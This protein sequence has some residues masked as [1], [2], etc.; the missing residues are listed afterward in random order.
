MPLLF[1]DYT[2]LI[3]LAYDERRNDNR[4]SRLL[5]DPT[6]ANIRQEC[7][8][9]HNERI[10]KGQIEEDIL[11]AFFGVPPAGK[12]FDYVIEKHHAD[13]FRPL[14]SLIKKKVKNPSLITVELLAWLLDFTPRPLAYAQKILAT[15]SDLLVTGEN[16]KN[17]FEIDKAATNAQEI[18]KHILG[19]R[20]DLMPVIHNKKEGV[21]FSNFFKGYSQRKKLMGLSIGLGIAIC[22]GLMYIFLQNKGAAKMA[23]GN[24]IYVCV[25]WSG[26]H[27]E[28]VACN[29]SPKDRHILT[30][31][32]AKVKSFRRITRTD[33]ITEWS[34]GRIYYIKDNNNIKYYTEAGRYPEDVNR[35]LKVLSPGIFQK[36]ILK[37]EVVG[38]DSLNE[39]GD[40]N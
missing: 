40:T 3:L 12:N 14:R 24:S 39:T 36:Y 21:F 33:T 25:Y 29:E 16:I 32:A 15:T 23:M 6:T 4:L 38:K 7:L 26:D 5:M 11:R 18:E 31:D 35:S 19:S 9:V 27:Y 22:L 13:K 34:I 2:N 30:M 20:E 17:S 37:K 10:K 8:N 28:E 1:K